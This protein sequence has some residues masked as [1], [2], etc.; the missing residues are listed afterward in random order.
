MFFRLIDKN[1]PPP[2]PSNI[3]SQNILTKDGD[4]NWEVFILPAN[5]TPTELAAE[6]ELRVNNMLFGEAGLS[7]VFRI[8]AD[9]KKG[10]FEIS[11]QSPY[12][13]Y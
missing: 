8:T 6:M 12:A 2:T 4:V 5:Y 3:N 7:D 13:F 10:I 1:K 11:T 9:E